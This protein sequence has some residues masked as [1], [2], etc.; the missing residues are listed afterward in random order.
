MQ[1]EK[2]EARREQKRRDIL[3]RAEQIFARQGFHS[4]TM[5]AVAEECG[6]SKGALYL[7]FE[8]KEDL[9]F[10]IIIEKV[11]Q[12]GRTLED[13][14]E[15]AEDIEQGIAA[16]IQTQF[17]FFVSNNDFFQL[18]VSEQGKILHTS[19]T[20]MR[21]SL[22]QKQHQ[23]LEMIS[24]ALSK[25]FPEGSPIQALTLSRSILGSINIHTLSWLLAPLTIDLEQIKNELT[26]LYLYGV[27]RHV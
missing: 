20:G 23:H 15:Q 24:L 5:E 7:H 25:H 9:F 12:L 27:K 13:A 19:D 1:S 3:Q 17:D 26:E 14:L 16:L 4:T 21:E 2:K 8:S 22:I 18:V 6:W 10:S 11:D